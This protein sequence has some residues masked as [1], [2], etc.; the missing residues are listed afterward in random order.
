MWELDHKIG[1]V[2]KKWCFWTLVFEKTLVSPLDSKEIKPVNPK[3]NQPWISIGRTDAKALILWLLDVKRWLTGKDPDEGKRRRQ[4]SMR[5]LDSITDSVDLNLNKLWEI[6]KDRG[7][8]HATVHGFT[9]SET[10]LINW[11][12][13]KCNQIHQSLLSV[14]IAMFFKNSL[15]TP[16]LRTEFPILSSKNFMFL[17]LS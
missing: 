3:G 5:W 12:T 1:W 6:M 11:T 16:R 8:W 17:F 10:Q 14:I 7:A 9:K 15:S 2:L 13:T 4:Q